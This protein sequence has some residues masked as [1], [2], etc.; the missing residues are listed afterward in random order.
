MSR[1]RGPRER[2]RES[3]SDRSQRVLQVALVG[4]GILFLLVGVIITVGIPV[5]P[6]LS[7]SGSG[8]NDGSGAPSTPDSQPSPEDTTTAPDTET[9]ESTPSSTPTQTATQTAEPTP[10]PTSTPAPTPSPSPTKTATPTPTPTQTATS[11]SSSTSG[12]LRIIN[13]VDSNGNGYVSDF[14]LEVHANTQIQGGKPY[15]IVKING[16]TIG[17]TGTL[18]RTANGVFTIG[19][20]PSTFESYQRGTLRVTVT[21]AAQTP[22]PD[23]KIKTWTK[24]VRY[25]PE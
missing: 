11:T 2:R 22:G 1:R 16:Q 19:L 17:E 12:N 18:K 15:F 9:Q 25:E 13:T 24:T 6:G 14:D 4:A 3:G 7:S 20:P 10:T 23:K 5:L 8:S 21:L